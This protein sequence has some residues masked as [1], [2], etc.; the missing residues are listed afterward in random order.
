MIMRKL[1]LQMQITLDGF[2]STGPHDEQKWVTWAWED[3]RQYVLE[4]AST[5]DTELIGRKLA[6]DYIPFWNETLSQPQAMLHEVAVM[7]STQKKI[8]FSKTL[9]K[10]PWKD[11]DVIS[12]NLKEAVN[13]LKSQSGK[14]IIVYGGSS[15][16]SSLIRDGLIDE[17]HLFINPIAIGRGESAFRELP[18]WQ[19][20]RLVKSITCNSGIVM[21]CYEK[22]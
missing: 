1:K 20:L 19:P 12:D 15:F 16:V 4:L 5:C 21:L 17:F 22:M 14:D 9:D 10:S 3:I 13:R 8:V 6:E 11:V 18:D 2:N 7:K